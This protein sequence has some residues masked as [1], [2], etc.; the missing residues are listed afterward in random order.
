MQREAPDQS[1]P[2]QRH[3]FVEILIEVVF[4]AEFD[5]VLVDRQDVRIAILRL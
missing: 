3:D 4:V 5:F 2:V 1:F